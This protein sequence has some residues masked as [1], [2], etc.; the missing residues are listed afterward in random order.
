MGSRGK[1]GPH[2]ASLPPPQTEKESSAQTAKE[3][4]PTIH[5]QIEGSDSL[6]AQTRA[7]EEHTQPDKLR[8]DS[9]T[10]N[11]ECEKLEASIRT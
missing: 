10:S 7:L 3:T 9:R 11:R 8:S 2:G 4:G 5:E 1:L 6:S